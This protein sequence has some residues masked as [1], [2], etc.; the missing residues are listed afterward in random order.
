MPECPAHRDGSLRFRCR[1]AYLYVP[2]LDLKDVDEEV[3]EL[4][5]QAREVNAAIPNNSRI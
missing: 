3:K 4:V 2:S 5:D 1:E